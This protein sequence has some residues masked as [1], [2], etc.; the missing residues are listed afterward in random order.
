MKKVSERFEGED[1][2]LTMK[3]PNMEVACIYE[4]HIRTLFE[5]QV[6][7]TDR[8]ALVKAVL[9]GD[10]DAI[11]DYVSG[12]LQK[13]I[14]TFDSEES[15]YHGFFLSLLY[16]V[17]YYSPQSNREEGIGRPDITL[18]P[19]RPKDPAI[20]FEVKVRKKFNEMEDGLKEAFDQIKTRKY[21]EGILDDG[22][23]GVKSYGIC[24]CKKSCIVG[25]MEG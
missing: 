7:D 15:F 25:K 16:G 11:A 10:T 14:S 18:Y 8:T 21:E 13:T 5:K 23:Y 22:Y 1:I 24:F 4:D 6:K 20:I 9:D 3:I 2:Y 12:L 17:P 19:D